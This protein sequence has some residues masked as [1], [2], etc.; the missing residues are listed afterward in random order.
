MLSKT[1][2]IHAGSLAAALVSILALSLTL[3]GRGLPAGHDTIAHLTYSFL[4]DRALEQGQFPVRWIESVAH[5][6]GQPLFNFYQPGLYYLVAL[7]QLVIPSLSVSLMLTVVALWW[8]GTTFVFLLARPWGVIPAAL[9][10]V[11][12]AFSPYLILDVFVRSAF[13]EFAA[14]AFAPGVLYGIDR[15][16]RAPDA[17]RLAIVAVLGAVI[18]V[19]HLPTALIFSPVFALYAAY[20]TV[21]GQASPRALWWVAA[22]AVLA[23]G[24]AAFY[25]VPAMTELHLINEATLTGG[26][27][28]YRQ[29]FVWPSQWVRADWGYGAS[30]EGTDDGMSFQIGTLQVIA[31]VLSAGYLGMVAVRRR[32]ADARAAAVLCWLTSGCLALFL[33][34]PWAEPIWRAVPVLAFVQY[35]WRYLMLVPV[36]AAMLTALLLS[37]VGRRGIQAAILLAAVVL[38]VQLTHTYLKPGGYLPPRPIQGHGQAFVERAYFPRGVADVPEPVASRWTLPDDDGSVT[39]ISVKD[40]EVI[41]RAELQRQANRVIRSFPFPGWQVWIDGRSA[42]ISTDP[43]GYMQVTVPA[44]VHRIHAQFTT[45]PPRSLGNAASLFSLGAC[46]V[47]FTAGGTKRSVGIAAQDG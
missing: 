35:P 10:A 28:D 29:H 44:G 19:C 18:L 40:H 22:G 3:L 33:M 25:I 34:T 47:L 30:V 6:Q 21:S 41:L 9:A 32:D 11:V 4:F 37:T 1:N 27:F 13:P 8:I 26:S 46:L 31:L 23:A 42:P 7:V 2:P 45:T 24:S 16:L 38:Q 36:S 43:L 17:R 15:L 5:G 12:Y 39:P 20:L 14:I